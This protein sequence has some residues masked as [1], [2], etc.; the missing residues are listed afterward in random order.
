M[1]RLHVLVAVR[2][3]RQLAYVESLLDALLARDHRV[4]LRFDRAWSRGVRL[5]GSGEGGAA[6][7]AFAERWP[8][9]EIKWAARRGRTRGFISAVRELRS[10]ATYLRRI[11]PDSFYTERWAKYLH[12][13]VR[14]LARSRVGGRML[15]TS[16][17]EGIFA[18]FER[19]V[20][21]ARSIVAEL[22]ELHPDVVVASPANMRFAEEVEYLKAAR[23][24]GMPTAVQAYSWDNLTTKGRFHAVP[25]LLLV[26]NELHAT[27]AREF[28]GIGRESIALSGAPFFDKWL[29]RGVDGEPRDRLL[30]QAGL[31]PEASY[32]L[33]MGSSAN[34]AKDET[35]VVAEIRWALDAAADAR[36]RD[37]SILVRPHPANTRPWLGLEVARTVVWPPEGR[38]PADSADVRELAATVRH[39]VGVVGVNTSGMI[40]AVA[41]DKATYAI[42]LDEFRRTQ[43]DAEHFAV[44]AK[45][46]AL[47]LV[48]DADE[49]VERLAALLDGDD[50]QGA[51]RRAFAETYLWPAQDGRP[52]GE[53]GADLI[54]ALAEA[55]HAG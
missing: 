44:L 12:D 13:R 27:A 18:L 49:L 53:V 47:G 19:A 2:S 22:R 20:P 6:M 7:R 38:L 25:D 24:L 26:W 5:D 51:G 10:Y 33:Y 42:V 15:A 37:A 48:Q 21:P 14:P 55:R 23:R 31:D 39:A 50:P 45:S 46:G 28:H 35:H 4:S 29:E 34:I 30:A 1:R 52:A 8:E 40:D 41:L 3:A 36:L 54:E 32:L 11:G 16:L 43:T 17:A 9:C